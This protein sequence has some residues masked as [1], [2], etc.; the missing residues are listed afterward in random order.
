MA[1]TLGLKSLIDANLVLV[2]GVTFEATFL[3]YETDISGDVPIDMRG[4]SANCQIRSLKDELVLDISE[5]ITFGEGALIL[6][7]EDEETLTIP[8]GKYEW[9]ML[10]EDTEGDVIRLAAGKVNVYEKVSK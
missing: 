2:R 6:K 1:I 10:L 4:W 8:A 9:D 7:I 3:Y 5:D